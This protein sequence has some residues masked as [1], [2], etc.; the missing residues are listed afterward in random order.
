MCLV[1]Y[2]VYV[3][4]VIIGRIVF[5]W[6]R[7]RRQ[8]KS[9]ADNQTET[10]NL[11]GEGSLEE[12]TKTTEFTYNT[13]NSDGDSSSDEEHA[14]WHQKPT[15]H[16]T[17]IQAAPSMFFIPKYGVVKRDHQEKDTL[18]I[19]DYFHKTLNHQDAEET[20]KEEQALKQVWRA[21]SESLDWK[22]KKWHQKFFFV[23]FEAFWVF[24]RNISIPRSDDHDW[25][26][27]F[28]MCVPIFA[29]LVL[30]VLPGYSTFIY[31]IDDRFPLAVLLVM[32]GS[33]LSIFI[34]FTSNRGRIPRYHP[35]FVVTAFVMSVVWIYLVANE[36]LDVLD[37]IG[38]GMGIPSS[39]LAITVL[40]W[41]N[42]ISD[43]VADVI[44]SRQG[45]PAMALGAVFSGQMLVS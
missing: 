3:L 11:I 42:S 16:E 18:V 37:A 45:F 44:I 14:K 40:S 6:L 21:I 38:T 25:N 10:S 19:S 22:E 15:F 29:P 28:A 39:I 1:I 23:T 8:A 32:I 9:L 33:L 30:L 43:M 27:W 36:L 31:M 35:V 2:F 7:K 26:K 34:F 17:T 5:K 24:L 13:V 20:E 41:G 4:T 12:E